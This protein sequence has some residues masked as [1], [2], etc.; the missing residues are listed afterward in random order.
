MTMTVASKIVSVIVMYATLVGWPIQPGVEAPAGGYELESFPVAVDQLGRRHIAFEQFN[1]ERVFRDDSAGLTVVEEPRGHGWFLAY[2]GHELPPDVFSA[3]LRP[4]GNGGWPAQ[5][6]E[7][8]WPKDRA[9]YALEQVDDQTYRRTELA[10]R[11]GYTIGAQFRPSGDG[12]TVDLE[13][14][15]R[16]FSG[17]YEDALDAWLGRPNV[18]RSV[19]STSVQLQ[20]RRQTVVVWYS[21]I[22][23]GEGG[24]MQGSNPAPLREV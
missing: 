18:V 20:D 6:I 8:P 17:E 13:M 24:G 23:R 4:D 3:L 14:S 21:P 7:F 11:V 22:I 1:G 9:S 15:K 2:E 5:S 12:M 16:A 10:V 19:V